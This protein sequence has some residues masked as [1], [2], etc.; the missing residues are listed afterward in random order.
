MKEE[1]GIGTDTALRP[2]RSFGTSHP[3]WLDLQ[4]EVESE[5]LLAKID[6]E[7]D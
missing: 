3:L 4:A 1:I 7:L 6:P 2:A 5:T